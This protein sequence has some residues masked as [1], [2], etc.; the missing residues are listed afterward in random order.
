VH[1]PVVTVPGEMQVGSYADKAGP[2]EKYGA[3]R[4]KVTG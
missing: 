4:E 2:L 1:H 3:G